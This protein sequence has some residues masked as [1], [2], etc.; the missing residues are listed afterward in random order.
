[1]QGG[2]SENNATRLYHFIANFSFAHVDAQFF[3]LNLTQ[4]DHLWILSMIVGALQFVQLKLS[5]AQSAK[6]APP[7]KQTA[8]HD[9]MQSMQKIML[10]AIPAM[11]VFFTAVWPSAVGLYWACSTFFGICQQYVVNRMTK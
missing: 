6:K 2:L 3:W 7:T 4:S 9:T 1:M 8:M 5:M 11:M 10:Y